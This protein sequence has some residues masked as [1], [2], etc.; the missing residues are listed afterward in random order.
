MNKTTPEPGHTPEGTP[1][2]KR[3]RRIP[4]KGKIA[5]V[6][7]GLADYMDIDVTVVRVVFVIL[8]FASAGFG[9][10]AYLILA[11]M[12]PVEG[13]PREPFD[14]K[15]IGENIDS[16]GHEIQAGGAERLRNFFGLLLVLLGAWLL[17]L[18]VFPR[19]AAI[20]W[21]LIWPAALVVIGIFILIRSKE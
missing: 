4:A 15:N 7:A 1:P 13:R 8:T 19:W 11:V 10:L 2:V 16:L 12:V 18:Q 5:G 6:C 20:D 9:I 3:L 14:A 17:L 21:A